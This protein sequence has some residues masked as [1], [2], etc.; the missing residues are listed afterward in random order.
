MKKIV[1]PVIAVIIILGGGFYFFYK[2]H[3]QKAEQP[4]PQPTATSNV[5]STP[6]SSV[7][8]VINNFYISYGTCMGNPPDAA[9]GKIS[10]YCQNNSGFTTAAFAANLEKGGTAKAGADPIYCSQ[11][12]PDG[13]TIN[14][15]VKVAAEKATASI[16]EKISTSKIKIQIDL[17]NESGVW[18]ID[19]IAC[20]LPK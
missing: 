17:L 14:P 3:P 10:V 7:S 1:L 2:N 20:P 9:A 15:D 19:N 12:P 11:N 8:E 13:I 4:T 18:K 6:E 16:T 5:P